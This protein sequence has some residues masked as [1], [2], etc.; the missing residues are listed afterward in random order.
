MSYSGLWRKRNAQGRALPIEIERKFV[1][2]NDTWNSA[3]IASRQLRDGL[4]PTP[5]ECCVRSA[6]AQ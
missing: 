2:A 6:V 4:M 5:M 1:V 3:A